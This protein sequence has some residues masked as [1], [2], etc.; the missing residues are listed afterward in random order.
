M[1]FFGKIINLYEERYPLSAND[2]S[3][4]LSSHKIAFGSRELEVVGYNNKNFAAMLS[5]KEYFEVSV[6]ALDRI[7]QL[8]FEF[9]I[10]QSFDYTYSQKELD[11]YEYQNYILQISGDED[12]RQISG[13]ANFVESKYGLATDYGKLQTTIMFIGKTQEEMEKD[14][15]D[16]LEQFNSLGFVVIREDIFSEHCFW[17]QL[18]GNFRYLRRQKVINTHAIAGF[19]ALHNFPAGLIAGNHWGSAVTVFRTVLNT[20]YFF[21]FHVKDLGHSMIIGPKGSGKTVLLNFL[22][23]QA[24]KFGGKLF[25]FDFDNS[26]KAFIKALSGSYYKILEDNPEDDEFLK[27]NPISLS[28]NDDNKAFLINFFTSLIIF[29]K[30]PVPAGEINAI[31]QIVDQIFFTNA[32]NFKDAIEVFNVSETRNIYEKL[33]IWGE[34]KLNKV[35]GSNAEINWSD[36]IIGFDFTEVAMQKP[37]AVPIVNY[38]LHRLE[39]ALDGSPTIIVFGETWSLVDDII[40]KPKIK[41]LLNRLRSKNAMV[42]FSS[43][44][45]ENVGESDFIFEVKENIATEIFLPNKDPNSSYKSGFELNDEEM[46]IVRMMEIQE[47]HFLFKHEGDSVIATLNLE[48]HIEFLKIL[49]ADAVTISAMEEVIAVNTTD[50]NKNP[51]VATW[52]PQLFEIL[53]ELEKERVEEEKQKAREEMIRERKALN[54][55]QGADY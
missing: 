38:L 27:L 51:T 42:I 24:Q 43:Q 22:L 26:A 35:F 5:L 6:A 25:Y 54:A 40:I 34:G 50:A 7:L 2:I 30:D 21:N 10:T 47:R 28:K 41:D 15:K 14:V 13:A 48:K 11:P 39:L 23:A 1:R 18:P 4:D 37:I 29:A 20:P 45:V 17:S 3:N 44:D 19:A 32:T 49:S 8:P 31:P 52:L 33:K 36:R 16:A 46:E 9:I 12:F 55:K 53:K